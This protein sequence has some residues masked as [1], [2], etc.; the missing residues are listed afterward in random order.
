MD[1]G[2]KCW[3]GRKNF[4]NVS[5][6]YSEV[7]HYILTYCSL[8]KS[9]AFSQLDKEHLRRK[10][11]KYHI[12]HTIKVYIKI[13]QFNS[14][15]CYSL[16][17]AYRAAFCSYQVKATIFHASTI[18]PLTFSTNSPLAVI[19]LWLTSAF[20]LKPINQWLLL[21]SSE[22]NLRHANYMW[23]S[24]YQR[25]TQSHNSSQ[26]AKGKKRNHQT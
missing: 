24:K 3:Y 21:S 4:I 2:H 9:K 17:K 1:T 15:S 25:T 13:I 5:L 6:S 10:W 23:E 22:L 26:Q 16:I 14:P 11:L 8:Q 12:I 18:Y 20:I 19:P 7:N